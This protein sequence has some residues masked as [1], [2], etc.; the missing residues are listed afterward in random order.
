MPTATAGPAGQPH[1]GVGGFHH[2]GPL[3]RAL[4]APTPLVIDYKDPEIIGLDE[5]TFGLYGWNEETKD[6]D[7]LGGVIDT[8][9]NT[10]TT[11]VDRLRT[12]TLAPAMPA[13]KVEMTAIDNGA[14]GAGE[15]ASRRFT[16]TSAPLVMNNGQ[17][18]PDGT[19]FTVRS[20]VAGSTDET[21]FGTIVT[22]DADSAR[23][24]TQIAVVNGRLQFD[25]EYNAPLG[26]Y[27]PGRVV[28]H[29]TFGTAYGELTLVKGEGQ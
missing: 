11:T 3:D 7:H 13:R 26:L 4:G 18:V 5:T 10:V 21:S 22:A 6:W 1:Y 25:V 12:Y 28:V 16:V 17:A 29:S 2:F 14:T 24:N 23:E 27:I 19:L 20:F 9:A 15:S 8:V